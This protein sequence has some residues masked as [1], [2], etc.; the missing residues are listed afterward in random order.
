MKKIST[1]SILLLSLIALSSQVHAKGETLPLEK[2][3]VEIQKEVQNKEVQEEKLKETPWYV[4][5]GLS[6]AK[7]S[8]GN[9][10][11]ITYGIIG[12]IGYELNDNI[13]FEVRG[14]RT[15]WDYEGAKIKHLGA[16]IKPQ[17]FINEDLAL[18]GLLGYAKTTLSYKYPFNETG[19]AYGIGVDYSFNND[20]DDDDKYSLFVDYERLLHK[21]NIPNIDALS[22]GLKYNF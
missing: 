18:Y 9:C 14:I 20:E 11:D 15:N 7:V 6:M 12:K 1:K 10:E 21:S 13:A 19:L 22:A 3:K 16:F 8:S 17:Y 4:A 5:G 2:N